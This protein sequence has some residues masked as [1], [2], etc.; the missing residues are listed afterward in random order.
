MDSC[1]YM[2]K[3]GFYQRFAAKNSAAWRGLFDTYC[4]GGLVR[5]CERNKLYSMETVGF[6]DEM[7]PSG[8]N[9]PGA[10]KMLL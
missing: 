7:M 5:H 8:K 10:F 1:K 6:S 4:K 3:C 9:V 2:G